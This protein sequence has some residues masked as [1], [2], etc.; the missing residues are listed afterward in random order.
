MPV[1]TFS[2]DDLISLIG[3]E[4]SLETLMDR[5]PQLGADVHSYDEGTREMSIEFFPDRPDLYSVEGAARALRTFLGYESGLT[6]YQVEDSDVVLNLDESIKEVRPY[7]VAGVV[8]DITITDAFIRSL[9]EMQE[10]LHLTMGRKRSKVSIGIHDMDRVTPPFTYKAVEPGSV[11]FVPLGKT[12]SMDL[13]EILQRHEKGVDYAY[14][15]DGKERYPLLVDSRG[16]VLSFPPIING[17]L[18]TVTE[19][20]K[21]VF[22]DVTGTDLSAIS[23]ALNIVATSMAERG[24]RIKRVKLQGTQQGMTPDLEPREWMLDVAAT[25]ALLGMELDAEGMA[26]ALAKMGFEAAPAGEQ[27]RVLAPA[28][29]LDLIHP[30]DL[31]ED[32]AKG[33]GYEN[34][35]KSLPTQQTFGSE[36]LV[37][38][39]ADVARQLMVGYGYME[40]TTLTLSSVKDQFE[41]MRLPQGEVVEVLNPISEDHTCLRVSLL[42]SLMLVLRRNKHRDL[43]QRLFEVGDVMRG[44]KRRRYLAGV[45][46]SARASFTEVKSLVESIMRDLSVRCVI[47]PSSTGTYLEGRGADVM[48]NGACIGSFGEIHPQVIVDFELGY[49]IAAFELDLEAMTEGK[50]ERVA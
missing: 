8:E 28:W 39:A 48:V 19:E 30:V 31:M 46:I 3:K 15:L 9:M 34:F 22:L 21:N 4:V 11:S 10:K 36:L 7:M 1:V 13:R 17:V 33:H 6:R 14:I 40:A 43:P 42:P 50:L 27:V 18:T 41:K 45:S 23:G 38:K 37:N 26:K 16:E 20:T 5:V 49:P 35:G 44:I 32:V 47:Q 24:G 2:Y 25:N 12:E 29:R